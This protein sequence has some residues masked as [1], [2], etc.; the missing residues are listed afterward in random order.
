M[1]R[2]QLGALCILFL[3]TAATVSSQ[4]EKPRTTVIPLNPIGVSRQE[5]QALTAS[6]EVELAYTDM[7]TLI[8]KRA[9]E[10]IAKEVEFSLSDCSDT[11]CALK[12][13]QM[14]SAENIIFGSVSKIGSRYEIPVKMIDMSGQILK[15]EKVDADSLQAL[16]RQIH[17]LAYRLAGLVVI[18]PGNAEKTEI[19]TGFVEVFINTTP[20]GA[21]VYVN[22]V[23]RGAAPLLIPKVP[24]GIVRIECRKGNLS[25]SKEIELK[26]KQLIKIELS[27]SEEK[28]NLFI[29]AEEE[30]LDVYL[31]DLLLS[32]LGTGLLENLPAGDHQL[33]LLGDW[34]RFEQRIR[35][36]ADKTTVVEA[37]LVEI[38]ELD[39]SL[40]RGATAE[41]T[42][43]GFS[44]VVSK[45]GAL[46]GLVAGDYQIRVSGEGFIPYAETVTVARGKFVRFEPT[47]QVM[48]AELRILIDDE[49]PY[50][51]EVR[52]NSE[53]I[54]K[55]PITVSRQQIGDVVVAI[56]QYSGTYHLE[57]NR[58]YVILPHNPLPPQQKLTTSINLPEHREYPPRPVLSSE[59]TTEKQKKRR[60]GWV[61]PKKFTFT[62]AGL[63]VGAVG[64]F[65]LCIPLERLVTDRGESFDPM[66]LVYLPLIGASLVSGLGVLIDREIARTYYEDVNVPIPANIEKN[67]RLLNGW[68]QNRK[69]VDT[70]N[71]RLLDQANSEIDSQNARV[72]AANRSRGNWE[73]R[74]IQ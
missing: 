1:A 51:E 73:F 4:V 54:G 25:T 36:S 38:G 26:G 28:G 10:E 32:K 15:A 17:D 14:L 24:A 3:S 52:I 64:G 29:K 9:R 34:L 11:G 37:R 47:L 53:Y 18:A 23:R 45:S 48:A 41:I 20:R 42:G 6:L 59:F 58:R 5:A 71:R 49:Y 55:T 68:E 67:Q 72:E 39:Y 70:W 50:P 44:K 56:G 74:E 21:E 40:P 57:S 62:Y 27:L 66:G 60:V 46:P 2:N 13:G 19:A 61:D 33:R 63:G 69:E 8:D 12:V 16:A 30:D 22:G 31:D 43:T 65:L 35:I 7:Y